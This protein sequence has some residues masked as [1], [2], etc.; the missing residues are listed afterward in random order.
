VLGVAGA[1]DTDLYTPMTSRIA[2]LVLIDVL[3]TCL[4]LRQGNRF[5]EHL[6][7]VKDSLAATRSRR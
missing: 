1:E 4:A 3:A 5:T 2:Q 7:R 6:Q